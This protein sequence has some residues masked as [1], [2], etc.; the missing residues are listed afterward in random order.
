MCRRRRG[1][2]GRHADKRDG[3]A[4]YFR[5]FIALGRERMERRQERTAHFLS[6]KR[7]EEACRFESR[8]VA[9]ADLKRS[10]PTWKRLGPD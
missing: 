4:S 10:R 1:G 2:G 3:A 9:C 7:K 6:W 8:C 5:G